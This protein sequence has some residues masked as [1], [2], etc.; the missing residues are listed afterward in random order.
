[1]RT[2]EP[3]SIYL[4]CADRRRPI[5][6]RHAR[7]WLA[8]KF[9]L[10]STDERQWRTHVKSFICT[11]DAADIRSECIEMRNRRGLGWRMI[12]CRPAVARV[13]MD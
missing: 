6:V 1:M 10:S 3:I 9:W 12:C 2:P 4:P 7:G 8:I 5:A 13:F 11:E